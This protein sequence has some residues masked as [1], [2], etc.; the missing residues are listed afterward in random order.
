MEKDHT[1]H[2]AWNGVYEQGVLDHFSVTLPSSIDIK[3]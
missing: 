3:M 1:K 2:L